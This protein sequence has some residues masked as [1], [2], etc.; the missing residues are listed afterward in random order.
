M[1]TWEV[2][3]MRP[4]RIS[5][6]ARLVLASLSLWLADPR[7]APCQSP[8]KSGSRKATPRKSPRSRKPPAPASGRASTSPADAPVVDRIALKGGGELLGQVEGSTPDGGL[9]VLARRSWARANLPDRMPRWEAEESKSSE[10]AACVRRDRLSA[11]RAERGAGLG[12]GDPIA[13]W[14]D[15]ELSGSGPSHA[16]APLMAIRL[17]RGEAAKV[18]R[19]GVPAALA[20]RRAWLAGL[21]DAGTAPLGDLE[22]RL[23]G[24]EGAAG[25]DGAGSLEPL[26]SAS[27]EPADRWVMRRAATEARHEPSLR[28]LRL[29][30]TVLPEPG[31]GQSPPP[32]AGARL[33]DGAIR[34]VLGGVGADPLPAL[35]QGVGSRGRVG[36]IVTRIEVSADFTSASAESSLYV[37]GAGGWDRAAWRAETVGVG[38]VPPL[39]T[40]LVASD[41]QVRSILQLVDSLGMGLVSPELK[42]RGLEVGAAAGAAAVLARSSLW[43]TLSAEAIDLGAVPKES[44]TSPSR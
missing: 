14:L 33:V 29:G 2:T 37:R 13:A 9:G 3:S 4:V 18:T 20:L 6:A 24:R 26:L 10:L 44:P 43:R 41:P 11:W 35:L 36:A 12:A 1:P 39:I 31:P 28:Y 21:D 25:G 8:P 34:D 19:A 17:G 5:K 40:E 32:D 16:A 38:S 27:A 22:R 30:G 7:P 42:Q 15:R 23:S